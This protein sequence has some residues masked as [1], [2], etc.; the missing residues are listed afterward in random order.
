MIGEYV[1]RIYVETKNR[2]KYI[3]R[4]SSESETEQGGQHETKQY[5]K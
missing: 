1:G 2:P 4:E 3:V 5:N